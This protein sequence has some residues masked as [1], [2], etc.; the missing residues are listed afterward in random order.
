[1]SLAK[2]KKCLKYCK[3]RENIKKELIFKSKYKNFIKKSV[4]IS[5]KN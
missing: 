5:K 3:T 2:Q 4:K 1:M